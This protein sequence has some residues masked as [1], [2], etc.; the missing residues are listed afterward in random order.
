VSRQ[1]IIELH[2]F[3]SIPYVASWMYYD[4]IIIES[5][6]NYTKQTFRNR[7]QIKTANKVE[8]LIV[9]IQKGNSN[10]PIQ[11][12]RIDYHQT[13]IKNHWGA[14]Q[15]AY[16][17]A[18]FFEHYAED[19][20][21]IFQKKP[22]FLFDLNLQILEYL[23]NVFDINNKMIFSQRYEKTYPVNIADLRSS[24]HP[25]QDL[26]KLSFYHPI[27]YMQVF[28]NQFVENL[29]ILDLI[30]SEGPNSHDIL[31]ESIGHI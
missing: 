26:K 15:S 7:C 27:E 4:E 13:W 29:S 24:I 20:E 31:I 28:G 6:E 16:G 30:F 17:K 10:I 5:K 1:A 19:V 8:D 3:P 11:E 25:K 2:Y 21:K 12:I 9:P 18:P 23:L 22:R 14:I